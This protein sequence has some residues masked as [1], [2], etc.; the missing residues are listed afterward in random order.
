[1]RLTDWSQQAGPSVFNRAGDEF[2]FGE[3]LEGERAVP[4]PK[5]RLGKAVAGLC[6]GR[7]VK[8]DRLHSDGTAI[9]RRGMAR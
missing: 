9:P 7:G 6:A 3:A 4:A 5:A 2:V 1:M 8:Q